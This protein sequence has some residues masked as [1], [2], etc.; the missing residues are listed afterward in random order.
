MRQRPLPFASYESVIYA[1]N[2]V[3]A[4][5]SRVLVAIDFIVADCAGKSIPELPGWTD[6]ATYRTHGSDLQG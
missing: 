5:Y 6:S 1:S 4:Q 3:S 2:M